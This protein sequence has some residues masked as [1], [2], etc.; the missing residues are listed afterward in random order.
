MFA[1]MFSFNKIFNV[2]GFWKITFMGAMLIQRKTYFSNLK[3]CYSPALA[4][5]R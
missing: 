1:C 3:L 5:T 4:A 2:T